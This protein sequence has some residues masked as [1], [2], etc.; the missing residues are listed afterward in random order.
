MF[1]F[2][3][4]I[5]YMSFEGIH[6]IFLL[7]VPERDQFSGLLQ[8]DV[9][10]PTTSQVPSHSLRQRSRLGLV[11][12]CVYSSGGGRHT[13]VLMATHQTTSVT[14]RNWCINHESNYHKTSNIRHT[15]ARNEIVDH[16]DAVGASPVGAAPTTSSFSTS[17]LASIYCT[18]TT[19]RTDEK[20]LSFG[21]WCHLYKR[22]YGTMDTPFSNF[23]AKG[24]WIVI[25][26]LPR[27]P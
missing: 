20:H 24:G 10:Q 17:H 1:H 5:L 11:A 4:S 22:F 9:N 25:H 27:S 21:I 19:A 8:D 26:F 15:L 12:L 13:S 23:T 7:S 6:I 16:S 18:N 3:P 2:M 14:K